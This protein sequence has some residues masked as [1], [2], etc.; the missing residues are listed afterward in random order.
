MGEESTG[1]DLNFEP[2]FPWCSVKISDPKKLR[3]KTERGY[4]DTGSDGTI[5]PTK[6]ADMLNLAAFPLTR[7]TVHGIGGKPEQRI[8]F[9][10]VFA[11]GAVETRTVVD[12]REDVDIILLGRDVLQHTSLNLCSKTATV[13][14][15]DP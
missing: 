10:A 11:I 6:T 14:V 13:T 9:G 15:T 12:I 8:L 2:P 4:L 7:A 3:S 5:V 1:F